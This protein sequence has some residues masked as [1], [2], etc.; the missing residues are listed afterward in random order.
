MRL[1]RHPSTKAFK[2]SAFIE[3]GDDEEAKKA[4]AEKFE[5][6]GTELV[7]KAKDAYLLEKRNEL[8]KKKESQCVLGLTHITSTD[9]LLQGRQGRQ[10]G[11][12]RGGTTISCP[13]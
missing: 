9:K 10:A 7:V 11:G 13:M 4:V 8:T 6:Q 12:G 2:G 3:F 1:R 5:Y